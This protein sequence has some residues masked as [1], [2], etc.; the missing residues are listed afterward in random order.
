MEIPRLHKLHYNERANS[1]MTAI[2]NQ[3]FEMLL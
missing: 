1:R 2:Y 3:K